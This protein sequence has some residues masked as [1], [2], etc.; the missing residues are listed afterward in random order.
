MRPSVKQTIPQINNNKTLPN[1]LCH[2]THTSSQVPQCLKHLI[3]SQEDWSSDPSNQGRHLMNT[4]NPNSEGSGGDM[5]ITCGFLASRIRE[6]MRAPDSGRDPASKEQERDRAHWTL[7]AGFYMC[8]CWYRSRY[9]MCID[10]GR[11]TC[12]HV[13]TN[14]PPPQQY[15]GLFWL[16]YAHIG[17]SMHVHAHTQWLNE[18]MNTE[19]STL[20][21][22]LCE[23]PFSTCP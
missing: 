17:M 16:P 15:K 18:G 8:R 4:C 14:T 5:N 21:N 3:H 11:Q 20:R 6:T 23:K 10:S 1:T 7:S 13:Q 12:M 19:G 22:S 2:T 9:P